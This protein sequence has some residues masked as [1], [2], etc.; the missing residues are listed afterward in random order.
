VIR[1]WN[2]RHLNE[3]K[4]DEE[5]GDH[6]GSDAHIVDEFIRC[7][8]G[9]GITTTSPIAARYSAAAGGKATQSF[10]SGRQ[11]LEIPRGPA[12]AARCFNRA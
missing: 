7:L 2:K 11:P 10:R 5:A 8:R 4:G 1:L 12:E 6:S 9:G 3:P